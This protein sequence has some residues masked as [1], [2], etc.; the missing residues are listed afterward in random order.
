MKLLLT[1]SL[2]IS[3]V[4]CAERAHG[5]TVL[6]WSGNGSTEGGTG[7]W[8][9]T[10]PRWGTVQTGP[11]TTVWNNANKDE[12]TFTGTA[13]TVTLAAGVTVSNLTC[14]G[15]GTYTIAAGNTVTLGTTSTTINCASLFIISSDLVGSGLITKSGGNTLSIGHTG[16]LSYSGK[17]KGAAGTL[18]MA[19]DTRFG[20]VPG[21][22]TADYLTL[23]G[24]ILRCTTAGTNAFSI[25]RGLT[26]GSGGGTLNPSAA[27][28]TM[29]WASKITGSGKLTISTGTGAT[30]QL[31]NTGNDYTG[32][33]AIN[34][35][36]ILQLIAAGV[37]PDAS[38]VTVAGT[39]DLNNNNE[40]VK[41]ISGAGSITL[42]TGTLTLANPAGET[43]SGAISETGKLVK[44]G[45][46][47]ITLS[48][49]NSF[50]GSTTVNAGTLQLGVANALA[51]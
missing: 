37:I 15:S 29:Q 10:N 18:S 48:G 8:D 44:N 12:A 23:D 39:F 6:F 19:S 20:P 22:V 2:L 28:A 46:G 13:G 14:N 16:T 41:S 32:N 45:T 33:T 40:T 43:F 3:S 17:W 49:A 9:T 34:S 30:V 1:I 24:G 4:L 31:S 7:T 51:T 21:S 47:M 27:S 42:G 36:A 35:G 25:N 11:Y 50:T 5:G 38:L 26:L